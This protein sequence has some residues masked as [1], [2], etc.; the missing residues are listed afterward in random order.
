[1]QCVRVYET[2]NAKIYKELSLNFNIAGITEF[3]NVYAEK[4]PEDENSMHD[5]DRVINAFNFDRESNKPHG[6]PF[7]FVI[8]SVSAQYVFLDFFAYL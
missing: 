4:I 1:M 3:V 8:K 2:H 6:V 5:G 7:K